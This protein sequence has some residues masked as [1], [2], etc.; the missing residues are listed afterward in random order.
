M[1]ALVVIRPGTPTLGRLTIHAPP[2]TAPPCRRCHQPANLEINA[3]DLDGLMLCTRCVE[4]LVAHGL[5]LDRITTNAVLRA[6][7]AHNDEPT[8]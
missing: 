2:P 1:I 7:L 8:P 3:G 5:T 4:H 6:A